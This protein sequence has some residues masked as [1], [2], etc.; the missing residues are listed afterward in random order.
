MTKV[1]KETKASLE[2]RYQS[3]SLGTCIHDL[4]WVG[5]VYLCLKAMSRYGAI[6]YTDHKV[7]NSE[8]VVGVFFGGGLLQ[9]TT[10]TLARQAKRSRFKF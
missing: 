8:Q 4:H 1:T 6:F 5:V 2:R 3:K 7:A 9:N 10:R